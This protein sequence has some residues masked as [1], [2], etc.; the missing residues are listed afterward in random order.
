M[1]IYPSAL[2]LLLDKKLSFK[3]QISHY[4][5][6]NN[7]DG[8]AISNFDVVIKSLLNCKKKKINIEHVT[9]FYETYYKHYTY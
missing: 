5:L 2:K 3:I 4:N 1:K 7:V 6:K 8:Y 9:F